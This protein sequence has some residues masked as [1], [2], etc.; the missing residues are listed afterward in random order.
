MI[1]TH[2]FNAVLR[3]VLLLAL[4]TGL[5][6]AEPPHVVSF[7]L[8]DPAATRSGKDKDVALDLSGCSLP[9]KTRLILEASRDFLTLYKNDL[10]FL[11]WQH[12]VSHYEK[13]RLPRDTAG[14]T[15][16]VNLT[17]VNAEGPGPGL[18]TITLSVDPEQLPGPARE[19][20]AAGGLPAARE[21]QFAFGR[22]DETLQRLKAEFSAALAECARLMDI[23]HDT[24]FNVP[25]ITGPGETAP[26]DPA[27]DKK[28]TE[29]LKYNFADGYG[30]LSGTGIDW[31]RRFAGEAMP[32]VALAL[33]DTALIMAESRNPQAVP[34]P[35]RFDRQ[36]AN[37]RMRLVRTTLLNLWHALHR[38]LVRAGAV[39][40]R[41]Q[42]LDEEG[43]RT[44][45]DLA[46]MTA[47]A[48]EIWTELG[49]HVDEAARAAY[50][51]DIATDIMHPDALYQVEADNLIFLAGVADETVPATVNA[52]LQA[53]LDWAAAA[54]ALASGTGDADI[55][56]AKV[57]SLSASLATAD[58]AM[59][60]L[61]EVQGK[62]E[63]PETK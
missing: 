18:Y 34:M 25:M 30:L 12:S 59:Y 14:H 63:E 2:R 3:G 31:G 42:A 38:E 1:R 45:A 36:C 48:Q 41:I 26:A 50:R 17:D 35:N 51:K 37:L 9:P 46:A 11:D 58:Q 62:L 60:S 54:Q 15:R 20:F 21:L 33:S 43:R 53:W 39:T 56:L 4:F 44:L 5:A 7:A 23:C 47:A 32:E 16:R 8:S 55:T 40:E 57:R 19:A 49:K 52:C 29:K 6:N 28:E 61:L 22:P 13:L 27:P 10:K 24:E